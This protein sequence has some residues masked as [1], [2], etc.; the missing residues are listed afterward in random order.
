M[1]EIF[2]PAAGRELPLYSGSASHVRPSAARPVL[3]SFSFHP[4]V[5][6]ALGGAD[7]DAEAL[8]ELLGRADGEPLIEDV[9]VTTI[10]EAD[11]FGSGPPTGL[12]AVTATHATASG[13]ATRTARAIDDFGLV[14]RAMYQHLSMGWESRN[15]STLPRWPPIGRPIA[16]SASAAR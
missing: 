12:H 16:D 8:R 3:V 11:G 14:R 10:D 9:G 6:V 15:A 7:A 2:M 4:T 5:A 13:A 1:P